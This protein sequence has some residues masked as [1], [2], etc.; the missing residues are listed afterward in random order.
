MDWNIIFKTVAM[1][2]VI[3]LFIF[4]NKKQ[5]QKPHS[6]K[7]VKPLFLLLLSVVMSRRTLTCL[8]HLSRFFIFIEMCKRPERFGH[9]CFHLPRANRRQAPLWADVRSDASRASAPLRIAAHDAK[10]YFKKKT[11][12]KREHFNTKTKYFV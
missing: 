2:P 1:V 11:K 12:L 3:L 8:A 9:S 6:L 4:F 7:S 5:K 10:S